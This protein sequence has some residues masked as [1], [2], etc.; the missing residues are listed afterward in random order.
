[1]IFVV[2]CALDGKSVACGGV[3]SEVVVDAGVNCCFAACSS[4]WE[5]NVCTGRLR[6]LFGAVMMIVMFCVEDGDCVTCGKVG[7]PPEVGERV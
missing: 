2:F 7:E 4:D 5:V 6:V 3:K 1:M